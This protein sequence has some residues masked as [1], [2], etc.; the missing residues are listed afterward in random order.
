MGKV[1]NVTFEIRSKYYFRK[2][3][4]SFNHNYKQF[5]IFM[6]RWVDVTGSHLGRLP[7]KYEQEHAILRKKPKLSMSSQETHFEVKPFDVASFMSAP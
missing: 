2:R 3:K 6:G 5:R 7:H 1:G 4:E